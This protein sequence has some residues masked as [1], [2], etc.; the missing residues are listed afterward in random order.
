MADPSNGL[1]DAWVYVLK[2]SL[3]HVSSE[4]R[5]NYFK[6]KNSKG[7]KMPALIKVECVRCKTINNELPETKHICRCA[8]QSMVTYLFKQLT[9]QKSYRNK[10]L[11]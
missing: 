9:T 11:D 3:L 6:N 7:V 5:G 8:V 4:R 2:G 10:H 1:A